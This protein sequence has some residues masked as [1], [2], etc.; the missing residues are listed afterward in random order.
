MRHILLFFGLTI[1]T[2]SVLG[3]KIPKHRDGGEFKSVFQKL[4]SGEYNGTV[5]GLLMVNDI[6]NS[7]TVFDFHGSESKLI[8][9][10][11]S[12]ALFDVSTKIYT[13]KTT[14]GDTEIEYKTYARS[15]CFG[16]KIAGAWYEINFIDGGCKWVIDGLEY[17]YNKDKSTECLVLQ[18]TDEVVLSNLPYII[19][20]EYTKNPDNFERL[21]LKERKISVL[22][23]SVLVFAI[24][25]Q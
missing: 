16:I 8:I 10:R 2:L 14:S 23:N 5:N 11:D 22:P 21:Q 15:N 1:S 4:I 17:T 24:K 13:G 20:T 7:E 25:R 9:Q 6:D 18:F 3:Q 19:R 12:G